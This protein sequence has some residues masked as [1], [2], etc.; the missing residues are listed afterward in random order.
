MVVLAVSFLDL[1]AA[2][3]ISTSTVYISFKKIRQKR[4]KEIIKESST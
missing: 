1:L 4:K 2:D 3:A